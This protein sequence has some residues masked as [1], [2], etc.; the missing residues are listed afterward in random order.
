MPLGYNWQILYFEMFN[1]WPNDFFVLFLVSAS[2]QMN[3]ATISTQFKWLAGG[4]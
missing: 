4:A 2:R 1:Y 3:R